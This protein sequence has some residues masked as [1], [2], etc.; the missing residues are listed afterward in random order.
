MLREWRDRIARSGF[1]R[2]DFLL[3]V[4][5]GVVAAVIGD[6]LWYPM[7]PGLVS[8]LGLGGSAGALGLYFALMWRDRRRPRPGQRPSGGL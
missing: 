3:A 2:R 5:M 6:L 7:G 8:W 1:R 4:P